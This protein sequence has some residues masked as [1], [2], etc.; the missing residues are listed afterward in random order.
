MKGCGE[1]AGADKLQLQLYH[2]RPEEGTWF[3]PHAIFEVS[4][5]IIKRRQLGKRAQLSHWTARVP[6]HH[7]ESKRP[8]PL[9]RLLLPFERQAS[10]FLFE[11]VALIAEA[12]GFHEILF[13]DGVFLFQ[14]QLLQPVIQFL[15]I[16]AL[17]SISKAGEGPGLIEQADRFSREAGAGEMPFG[18][19]HGGVQGFIFDAHPVMGLVDLA[20]T[21]QDCQRFFLRRR[22]DK[23]RPETPAEQLILRDK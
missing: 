3:R 5:T 2:Q 23:D 12:R 7:T 20:Q 16:R 22:L 14:V 15:P 19:L 13:G 21:A 9:E 4:S 1:S 6:T 17:G 8:H 11:L 10:L 18:K